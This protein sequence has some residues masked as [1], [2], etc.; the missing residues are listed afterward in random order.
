MQVERTCITCNEDAALFCRL[1]ATNQCY[2]H[3]CLHL[4]VAHSD[5]TW[6]KRH[7]RDYEDQR[8]STQNTSEDIY[9]DEVEYD[10]TADSLPE[11]QVQ[12]TAK[13]LCA[14]SEAQLRE[15]YNFYTS[16]ARRIRIELD[17]RSLPAE[18]ITGCKSAQRS[19]LQR[20][21]TTAHRK[22]RN[23]NLGKSA[24]YS[25]ELLLGKIRAGDLTPEQLI[26][27]LTHMRAANDVN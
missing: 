15:Q 18:G 14:Y 5:N 4:S 11:P 22:P 12:P 25:Y 9:G 2:D 7:E 16:Q 3:M 21:N 20:R 10:T 19:F 24:T 1:C 13:P 8:S 17:R 6:T 26:T 23:T 27:K